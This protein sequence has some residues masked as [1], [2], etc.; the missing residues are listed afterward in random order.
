[1]TNNPLSLS[2][3]L[4][5][6]LLQNSIN[7]LSSFSKL[8]SLNTLSTNLNSDLSYSKILEAM[9]KKVDDEK[10]LNELSELEEKYQKEMAPIRMF[11]LF[12]DTYITNGFFGRSTKNKMRNAKYNAWNS[13][14]SLQAERLN[15]ETQ[16]AL[17]S[18]I[19]QTAQKVK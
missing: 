3:S 8:N 14:F 7:K 15:A 4:D 13:I 11:D 2:N 9:K 17:K 6:L 18:A 1:M 12:H 16:I 5:V 19:R 10:T